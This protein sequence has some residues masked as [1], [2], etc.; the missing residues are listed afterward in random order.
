MI[1]LVIADDHAIMRGGLKQIVALTSD[2]AV[3]GEATDGAQMIALVRNLEFDLLLDMMMPG[4]SGV[5]LIQRVRHL[6]P[7]LPILVLSMNNERQIVSRAI[8]AGAS[9]YVTKDIHPEVLLSAI[10]KVAAGGRFV[11]PALLEDLLFMKE[12]HGLAPHELLSE[13][14]FQ[15]MQLLVSGRQVSEIATTLHLSPK[16]VSTYKMRLMQKLAIDNNAD[17]VRYA[18]QHG[19]TQVLPP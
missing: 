15:I 11:E 1:R 12:D 13:R 4:I 17:L 8:K 19:I 18:I 3:A 5:E 16:T 9:G 10:R 6:K 14:E 7:A 2:I